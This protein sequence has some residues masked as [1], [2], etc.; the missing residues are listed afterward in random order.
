MNFPK[1]C[2]ECVRGH[3]PD[4]NCDHTRAISYYRKHRND[5]HDPVVSTEHATVCVEMMSAIPFFPAD[6]GARVLIASEVAAICSDDTQ[7]LWLARR[8][9][10]LYSSWPGIAEMRRMFCATY[11][12]HD[13]VQPIGSSEIYGDRFPNNQGNY[14][15]RAALDGPVYVAPKQIGE[16]K[17]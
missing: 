12:P 5:Y 15:T 1:P 17:S 4:C 3:N 13:G 7:A 6:G 16:S 11:M 2:E 14:N 10:R 8:M 9:A